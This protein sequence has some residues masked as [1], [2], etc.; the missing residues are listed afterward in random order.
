MS[1]AQNS[2]RKT[3]MTCH[4]RYTCNIIRVKHVVGCD[5]TDIIM[6]GRYAAI[7]VVLTEA[8]FSGVLRGPRIVELCSLIFNLSKQAYHSW[9]MTTIMAWAAFFHKTRYGNA[10]SG[11]GLEHFSSSVCILVKVNSTV[12]VRVLVIYE[13]VWCTPDF[14][15]VV[16]GNHFTITI[17]WIAFVS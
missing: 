7:N 6:G 5:G 3:N 10:G 11:R 13:C 16:L 15:L 12:M 17:S 14:C 4:G 2:K 1:S 8:L 9:I